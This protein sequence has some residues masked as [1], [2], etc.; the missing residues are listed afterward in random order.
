MPAGT[1][2]SDEARCNWRRLSEGAL[3]GD[4]DTII[5]RHGQPV[6]ALIPLP[7][8]S[9]CWSHWRS[10]ELLG[11]QCR[12]WKRGGPTQRLPGL[13]GKFWLNWA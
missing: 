12:R 10:C 6:G 11:R 2:R 1:M 4:R 13:G 7:V 9:P 8:T 5:E 3:A